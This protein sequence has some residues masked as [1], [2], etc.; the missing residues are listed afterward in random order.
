MLDG[1]PTYDT[2]REGLRDVIASHITP[3]LDE[4]EATGNVPIHDLVR[5]LADRNLFGFRFAVEDG[6][7]GLDHWA[8][9]AFAEE[10]GC[11]RAGGVGMA[12]TIHGDMVLPML[13]AG[14]TDPAAREK[15][16]RPA[17]RGDVIYSHAISENGAG[18]DP[19]AIKT[20]AV[21]VEGGYRVTGTKHCISLAPLADAHCILAKVDGRPFPFNMVLLLVA[22]D[23][24]GVTVTPGPQMMGNWSCRVGDIDMQDVFVPDDAQVGSPGMGFVLQMRQFVEERV[25]SATRAV[26]AS[27]DMIDLT[28]SICAGR[29]MFGAT[30]LDLQSVS[31]RLVDLRTEAV[32]L[33]KLVHDTMHRWIAGETFETASCVVKLR[34]NRLARAVGAECMKLQ[35]ARGYTADSAISRFYR[36]GRLYAISTGSDEAMQIA[37]ARELGKPLDKTLPPLSA[38]A[39]PEMAGDVGDDF[40]ATLRGLGQSGH[41]KPALGDEWFANIHALIESS[42]TDLPN[43]QATSLLTHL[44]VGSLIARTGSDAFRSEW[45]SKIADGEATFALAIT[46]EKAGSDFSRLET[47][48]EKDGDDWVLTGEKAYITN[49]AHADGFAVLAATASGNPLARYTLFAVPADETVTRSAI[50]TV[51]NAGC[52]GRV[53][54]DGTRLSED[55]IIGRA[56]QGSF[57]IQQHLVKER[58]FIALRCFALGK[59]SLARTAGELTKR[60]TFGAPLSTR[61]ALQFRFSDALSDLLTL[62]AL[63]ADLAPRVAAKTA[64]LDDIAAAKLRANQ[65]LEQIAD[66]EIQIAAGEGY[67]AAHPAA[68]LYLDGIGLS[69]AGGS[70]GVL[71]DMIA[72]SL[73]IRTTKDR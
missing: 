60:E 73:P 5:T 34:S 28:T 14:M 4:W 22:D 45:T 30:L 71:K 65:M 44:D 57:L 58:Y 1:T 35:G 40:R 41:L 46:E 29:D 9:L 17:L 39:L 48:A 59:A 69:I 20:H 49:G 23:A 66:F 31:H 3:H 18:S 55:N 32:A 62:R 67:A 27:T 26:S 33:R 21:K 11:I 2:I 6:G 36:D 13:D 37:I 25:I 24:E 12:L 7:Q 42:A 53:T 19:S 70:D 56:G 8:H 63:L 50:D 68:Q 15:W 51:G 54:F 16:L 10:I 52:L 64:T 47:T 72:K 43:A 38:L 61:Q